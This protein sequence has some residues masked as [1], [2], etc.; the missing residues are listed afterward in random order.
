VPQNEESESIMEVS[1]NFVQN[2][3]SEFEE[4]RLDHIL[5]T[6]Q[7][8]FHYLEHSS[9]T[10][11]TI[12]QKTVVASVSSVSATT[13][14]YTIQP[15][16]SLNGQLTG[17]LYICLQELD[18]KFGPNVKISVDSH[19]QTCRN[20]VVTCSKSG[21]LQ[22]GHVKY[23][24]ENVLSSA[25]TQKCLLILDSWTGQKDDL[26][27]ESMT[28]TKKCN[29][30]QIPPKATQYIQ[31]LDVYGFRQW[32]IFVRKITDFIELHNINVDINN[33]LNIITMHSLIHYQLSSPKF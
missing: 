24:V 6:D 10:L 14:S 18:G 17:P 3:V 27:F 32:K 22:K 26:L 12:G 19:L 15:T 30:L 23:W 2:A 5:N 8:D 13:H 1:Q 11:A 28:G 29:R 25:I 16:I 31:P 9:H 33:R 7:S 21:K 20:I 4:Y